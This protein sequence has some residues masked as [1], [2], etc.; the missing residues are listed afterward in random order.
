M[1]RTAERNGYT[2][3]VRFAMAEKDLDAHDERFNAHEDDLKALDVKLGKMLGILVG[4]LVSTSTAAILLAL[5]LA[6][7]R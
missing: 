6:V 7:P 3:E 5:N 2:Q 1:S 4:I